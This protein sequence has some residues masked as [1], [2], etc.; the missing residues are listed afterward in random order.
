MKKYN[1]MKFILFL[2]LAAAASVLYSGEK[3]LF[4]HM[5]HGENDVECNT[6]HPGAKTSTQSKENLYPEKTVCAGECHEK[7]ILNKVDFTGSKPKWKLIFNHKV[8]VEQDIKC[9]TCHAGINKKDF[10]AGDAFPSMKVCFKCHNG[11]DAE[12]T[13]TLCHEEKV[14]FPHKLHILDNKLACDECHKNIKKS[15]TTRGG[16][17]I[18]P[19]NVCNDCH[20]AELKFSDVTDFPYRQTYEFN[21]KLHVVGQELGCRECHKAL[22]EKE[23]PR[24]AELVPK[25]KYCFECHDNDTATKYCMLCHLNPTKPRDHYYDW[26]NMHKKSAN[27]DMQNCISCHR[28]R[29]FCISCHKGIK[30]P[31]KTHSPNFELTHRFEARTTLKNCYSCHSRRQC[32]SCHISY[33]VSSGSKTKIKNIHGPL[34]IWISSRHKRAGRLRIST[35]KVCHVKADCYGCH[36]PAYI[37]PRRR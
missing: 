6:C 26:D 15:T 14:P 12:K 8:H 27:R 20:E 9:V 5:T 2:A 24:Q 21:H 18:P 10:Q 19:K 37:G 25:M 4:P 30:K 32:A 7:D 1:Y 22:Y 11:D 31:G 33:G 17:D 3:K 28:S 35:C 36:N 23:H 34:G 13:C 16:R 29:Q